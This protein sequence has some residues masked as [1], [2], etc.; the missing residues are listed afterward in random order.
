MIECNYFFFDM[1]RT[2]K[3]SST[4]SLYKQLYGILSRNYVNIL[5]AIS[6]CLIPKTFLIAT[7]KYRAFYNVLRDY[8]HL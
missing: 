8:K 7:R 5:V 6:M 1:F 2:T 3:C 4:G